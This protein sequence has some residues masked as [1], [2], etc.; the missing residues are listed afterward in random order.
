MKY[1]L[2]FFS[3]MWGLLQ[4]GLQKEGLVRNIEGFDFMKYANTTFKEMR[5]AL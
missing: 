5:K 2:M 4:H 1:M 3:A